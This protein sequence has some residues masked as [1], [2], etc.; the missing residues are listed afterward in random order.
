MAW[1]RG[2]QISVVRR[3]EPQGCNE[4]ATTPGKIE[5]SVEL[6]EFPHPDASS[7][8]LVRPTARAPS[9][10]SS[11]TSQSRD[12][13]PFRINKIQPKVSVYIPSEPG[14]LFSRLF[15]LPAAP[16]TDDFAQMHDLA[17]NGGLISHLSTICTSSCPSTVVVSSPGGPV[18]KAPTKASRNTPS[19][20][21]MTGG[22]TP[23]MA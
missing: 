15:W 5:R 14:S 17:L 1:L 11:C 22:T 23:S 21:L 3:M 6:P 4:T 7:V 16:I 10:A 8:S 2:I 20:S 18:S 12:S 19:M 13:D 9:P